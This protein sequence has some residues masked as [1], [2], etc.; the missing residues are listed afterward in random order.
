MTMLNGVEGMQQ[1]TQ[2]LLDP[3]ATE[4]DVALLDNIIAAAY[5]PSSPHRADANRAL[6]T[7]QE[8]P[9]LWTKADAILEKSQNANSRF[10]GLQILDDTIRTRYVIIYLVSLPL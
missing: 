10:F 2:R 1:A 5:D 7:L 3:N 4:F 8:A 6:M 9:D